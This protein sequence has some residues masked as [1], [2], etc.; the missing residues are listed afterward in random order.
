MLYCG[1][2]DQ[3]APR[4]HLEDIRNLKIRGIVPEAITVEYHPNLTHDFVVNPQ[5]VPAVIDFCVTRIRESDEVQRNARGIG[6]KNR[7]S[8]PESF[9]LRSSL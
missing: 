1:G 3:W 9:I 2:P 6:K 8:L 4:D 5:M 7:K